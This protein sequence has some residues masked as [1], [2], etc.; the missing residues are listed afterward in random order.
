MHTAPKSFQK[1]VLWRNY[2][3]SWTVKTSMKEWCTYYVRFDLCHIW[4]YHIF[5]ECFTETWR[6][7]LFINLIPKTY[8]CQCDV[9]ILGKHRS[10]ET[11]MIFMMVIFLHN[12]FFLCVMTTRV[13]FKYQM[14]GSWLI[15]WNVIFPCIQLKS[16]HRIFLHHDVYLIHIVQCQLQHGRV[17]FNVQGLLNQWYSIFIIISEF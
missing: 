4:P 17:Y 2:Y 15:K 13:A 3:L 9:V 7:D 5:P 16:H 10:M 12:K 1:L 14:H 11:F 6:T 8:K